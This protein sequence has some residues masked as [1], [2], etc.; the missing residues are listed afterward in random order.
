MWVGK[1]YADLG[2]FADA[3]EVLADVFSRYAGP[4]NT[5]ARRLLAEVRW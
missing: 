2:F 3:V 4:S 1:Q 5:K